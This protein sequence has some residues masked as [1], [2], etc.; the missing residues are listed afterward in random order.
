MPPSSLESECLLMPGETFTE[1]GLEQVQRMADGVE[2]WVEPDSFVSPQHAQELERQRLVDLNK[3]VGQVAENARELEAIMAS[4]SAEIASAGA[5]VAE[6][7]DKVAAGTEDIREA[8]KERVRLLPI[9][10]AGTCATVGGA[11]G[12][13]V[14]MVPGAAIG[15]AV[16][17]AVGVVA[18]TVAKGVVQRRASITFEASPRRS[19]TGR[20][21]RRCASADAIITRRSSW[22]ENAG[23]D[24]G[25]DHYYPGD[26]LR[27][28]SKKQS[29]KAK[30]GRDWG[31]DSYQL[32]DVARAVKRTVFRH[33]TAGP[34]PSASQHS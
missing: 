5:H 31:G 14:G 18:G 26:V 17:G 10:A 22:Q 33:R 27:T 9:Q 15:A 24:W 23:R 2:S 30:S 3:Q 13:A 12:G 21:L 34:C 7:A 19:S 11:V 29:W 8:A 28:L 25:P 6:A 20:Q 1:P 32:F 16:G 4:G